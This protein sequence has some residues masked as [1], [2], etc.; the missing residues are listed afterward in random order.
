M[1]GERDLQVHAKTIE[2][3]LSIPNNIAQSAVLLAD[4]AP[5]SAERIEA[6]EWYDS[7]Y[8][9]WGDQRNQRLGYLGHQLRPVGGGNATLQL[10]GQNARTRLF[11][12]YSRELPEEDDAW[13]FGHAVQTAFLGPFGRAPQAL[14][15]HVPV[16]QGVAQQ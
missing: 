10:A 16:R 12:N 5:G 1:L 4:L 15:G 3:K 2:N 13:A 6:Q 11:A 9:R 14:V 7:V 8:G